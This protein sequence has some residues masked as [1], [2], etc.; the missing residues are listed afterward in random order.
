MINKK[1]LIFLLTISIILS[2]SAVSAIDS[3]NIDDTI[4]QD[5]TTINNEDLNEN[6]ELNEEEPVDNSLSINNPILYSTGMDLNLTI[7]PENNTV[8]MG[9]LIVYNVTVAN[10]GT[11]N[12]ASNLRVGGF[13]AINGTT[14]VSVEPQRGLYTYTARAYYWVVGPLRPNQV[15]TAIVTLRVNTPNNITI[16]HTIDP[17]TN[18]SDANPA[19]NYDEVNITVLT[20]TD[21]DIQINV[22][23]TNPYVFDTVEYTITVTNNGPYAASDVNVNINPNSNLRLISSEASTGRFN[24]AYRWLITSFDAYETATLKVIYNVTNSGSTIYNATVESKYADLDESNNYAEVTINSNKLETSLNYINN[25]TSFKIVHPAIIIVNLEDQY[26]NNISGKNII[27]AI[28]NTTIQNTTDANGNAY[29]YYSGLE[30]GEYD[31]EYKFN[32]GR[33]SFHSFFP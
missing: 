26:G 33:A 23:N 21:L 14:L 25:K 29:L 18:P 28:N 24:N 17:V 3:D 6:I 19:D 2:I 31:V 11:S 12:S 13:D 22:N 30:I 10:I 16:N 9:D 15:A 8:Y 32:E 7:T 20:K 1:I 4:L 27:F 5:N